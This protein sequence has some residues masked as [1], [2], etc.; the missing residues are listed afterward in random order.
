MQSGKKAAF[1]SALKRRTEID[2]CIFLIFSKMIELQD[3]D[4]VRDLVTKTVNV[5]S[6]KAFRVFKGTSRQRSH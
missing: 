4:A 3:G 6:L 1:S 5:L 2:R